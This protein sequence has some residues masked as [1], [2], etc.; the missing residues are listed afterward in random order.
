MSELWLFFCVSNM[1]LQ[2]GLS[3]KDRS[4]STFCN[5]FGNIVL[6]ATPNI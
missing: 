1:N 5:K 4:N 3:I 2:F 6:L